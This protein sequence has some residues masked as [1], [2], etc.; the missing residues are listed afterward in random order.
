MEIALALFIFSILCYC[1]SSSGKPK[2]ASSDDG[3]SFPDL[4][5]IEAVDS[6][7]ELE[8]ILSDDEGYDD[9]DEDDDEYDEED[10]DPIDIA[11]V[12]APPM[13]S[14]ELLQKGQESYV[15]KQ[16]V[17][18]VD[19]QGYSCLRIMGLQ[20][21]YARISQIGRFEGY[22]RAEINNEYDAYA[23]AIYREDNLQMGYLPAGN[24]VLHG[25]ILQQGGCV[26]CEGYIATYKTG[27][28]FG[29]VAVE[30]NKE[31][32]EKRN[33][34]SVNDKYYTYEDG[35]LKSFL[36]GSQK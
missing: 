15:G 35:W 29:A 17:R 24:S 22:A 2:S 25:Y 26:H 6:L 1:F 32:V 12:V 28:L 14:G 31:L 36:D 16:S 4:D 13:T 3:A 21:Y 33:Q 7:E 9:C 20:H 19:R 18:L 30:S 10:N 23:I 11:A 27:R 8:E 34:S 5:E